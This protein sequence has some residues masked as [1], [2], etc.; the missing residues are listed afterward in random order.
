MAP[1]EKDHGR[2]LNGALAAE[3]RSEMGVQNISGH[4]LADLAG[5]DRLTLRRYTRGERALTTATVEAVA[6]ALGLDPFELMRRAVDRRDRE[7][8][9]Y[10]PEGED[11]GQIAAR[12][13]DNEPPRID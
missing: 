2:G 12:D 7:P 1:V 4:K 9:L 5:I 8:H 6:N 3:I 10:G 11:Q 13:E